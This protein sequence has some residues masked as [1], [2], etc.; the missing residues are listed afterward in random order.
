MVEKR[1]CLCP[2]LVAI[3]IYGLF[4]YFPQVWSRVQGST[5]CVGVLT[6]VCLISNAGW[7]LQVCVSSVLHLYAVQVTAQDLH[8]QENIEVRMALRVH[9]WCKQIQIFCPPSFTSLNFLD[10]SK[11]I[12]DT[13]HVVFIKTKKPIHHHL[14]QEARIARVIVVHD[15]LHFPSQ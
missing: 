5:C 8:G 10:Y 11:Q 13:A 6:A 3:G 14:L 4:V 2:L 12:N 1:S 7:I 15:S 9:K